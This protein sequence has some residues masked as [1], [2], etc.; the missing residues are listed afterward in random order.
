MCFIHRLG[1]DSAEIIR[2]S[3]PIKSHWATEKGLDLNQLLSDGPYKEKYRKEMIIWS[4]QVRST[5]PGYFC[6]A[7]INKSIFCKM[8]IHING[9]SFSISTFFFSGTKP[10]VIISDVRRKSD[11]KYF[12]DESFSIRAIRINVNDDVRRKR[13]WSF[14][15]GVD[16]VQ[17][18]CDLDD[19]NEWDLI[20][21]NDDSADVDLLLSKIVQLIPEL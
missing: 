8:K 5:D 6:R 1:T 20:L 14:E 15:D 2:I 4:D 7:A 9:K 17:S 3:E 16:N 18:E 12:K 13:G 21:K 10:V 11:I 19:F